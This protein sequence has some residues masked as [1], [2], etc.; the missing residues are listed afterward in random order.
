[1]TRPSQRDVGRQENPNVDEEI[2]SLLKAIE[3]ER[4]PDRLTELAIELQN[5][6]IQKR[7]C[8]PES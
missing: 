4:V 6:L 2:A 5:A 8:K 7:H 3:Q 1:M